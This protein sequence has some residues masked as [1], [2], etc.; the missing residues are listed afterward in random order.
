MASLA[1]ARR[2]TSMRN[3]QPSL[4]THWKLWT[5]ALYH[6]SIEPGGVSGAMKCEGIMYHK[7]PNET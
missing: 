5:N 4:C 7:L 2:W 1:L 6:E 3:R